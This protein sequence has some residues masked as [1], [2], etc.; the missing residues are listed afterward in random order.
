MAKMV[1][2]GSMSRKVRE[3]KERNG[4]KRKRKNDHLTILVLR[5]LPFQ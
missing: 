4:K 5:V 2:N 1:D 3:R